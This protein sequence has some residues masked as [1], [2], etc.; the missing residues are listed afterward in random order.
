M[1]RSG[2]HVDSMDVEGIRYGYQN[3]GLA[4]DGAHKMLEHKITLAQDMS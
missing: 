3:I 4:T 2:Y 1:I